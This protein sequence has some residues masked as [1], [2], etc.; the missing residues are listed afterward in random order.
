VPVT[1]DARTFV[2]EVPPIGSEF[3][4]NGYLALDGTFINSSIRS[5]MVKVKHLY[6]EIHMAQTTATFLIEEEEFINDHTRS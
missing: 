2:Q 1:Y 5:Y 6:K 3:T 4:P